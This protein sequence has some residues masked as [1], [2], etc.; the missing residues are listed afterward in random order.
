MRQSHICKIRPGC[1]RHA[2]EL[3]GNIPACESCGAFARTAVRE[4]AKVAAR[5][6][7][8]AIV[9]QPAAVVEQPVKELAHA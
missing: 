7:S 2:T 6:A 9:S 1:G 5:L 4:A 8:P 3:V